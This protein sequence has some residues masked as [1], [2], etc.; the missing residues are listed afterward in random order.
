MD[1]PSITVELEKNENGTLNVWIE[2]ENS[3]GF[4]YDNVTPEQIGKIVEE[5]IKDILQNNIDIIA[6]L[7]PPYT[8]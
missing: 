3:T 4:H 5:E 2:K 6:N 8:A 1:L 7:Y